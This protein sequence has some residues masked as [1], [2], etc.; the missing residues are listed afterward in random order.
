MPA[1]FS[2]R[3][4][5]NSACAKRDAKRWSCSPATSARRETADPRPVAVRAGGLRGHGDDVRR[6]RHTPTTA[7]SKR[8]WRQIVKETLARGGN[9]VIPV[10]AVERAQE[11]IYHLGRLVHAGR[12]PHVD[13]F[14]DS[15]MAVD[16]TT[17]FRKYPRVLRRGDVAA[18]HGQ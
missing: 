17:I 14:L 7:T 8:S 18:D 4:W 16:V 12:I 2:V 15:P 11:L 9:L 13:V 1:T 5:W 10:F 3:P 6:P